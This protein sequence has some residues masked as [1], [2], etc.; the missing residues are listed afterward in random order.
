MTKLCPTCKEYKR[1]TDFNKK[2][3]RRDGLSPQCRA[4]QKAYKDRN[5]DQIKA[6]REKTKDKQRRAVRAWRLK[7][8]YGITIEEYES[9]LDSQ[10]NVCK[11][12]G[13][14][15][16]AKFRGVLKSLAVDHCHK[17]GLVRGIICD[18]CN[19]GIARFRDNPDVM[20]AAI[21]YLEDFNEKQKE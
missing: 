1:S 18:S 5:K 20:R 2:S 7:N 10:G 6:Y 16:T 13:N 8:D 14:P 11:I 17:T 21:Q 9:I 15:E 4:C 19:V 12:C 3:D